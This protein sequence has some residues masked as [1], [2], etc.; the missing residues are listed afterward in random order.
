MKITHTVLTI[1]SRWKK[2]VETSFPRFAQER[3]WGRFASRTAHRAGREASVSYSH[4]KCGNETVCEIS[5][6]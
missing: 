2:P 1:I 4:A 3:L 5:I 6:Y